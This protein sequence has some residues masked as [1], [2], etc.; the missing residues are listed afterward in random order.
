MEHPVTSS[1]LAHVHRTDEDVQVKEE[2]S[3]GYDTDD[4]GE[5]FVHQPAVSPPSPGVKTTGDPNNNDIMGGESSTIDAVEAAPSPVVLQTKVK[6]EETY[7]AYDTDDD[8]NFLQDGVMADERRNDVFINSIHTGPADSRL[9]D[10]SVVI[11]I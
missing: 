7:Y 1:A 10:A 6:E 3:Y 9:V 5:H 8:G 4:N 2:P 11:A